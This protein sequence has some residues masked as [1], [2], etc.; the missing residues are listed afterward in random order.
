[1]L[2]PVFFAILVLLDFL[3]FLPEK[4]VKMRHSKLFLKTF[5]SI[6]VAVLIFTGMSYLLFVCVLDSRYGPASKGAHRAGS[7]E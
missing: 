3:L 4:K 1:L 5:S 2:L 7:V 6:V